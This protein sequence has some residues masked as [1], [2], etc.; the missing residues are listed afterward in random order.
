M[1]SN[2]LS[3]DWD[4][5]IKLSRHTDRFIQHLWHEYYARRQKSYLKLSTDQVWAALYEHYPE[6]HRVAFRNEEFQF[7]ISVLNSQSC[8]T[9]V[10]IAAEH[11]YMY[12]FVHRFNQP[13]IFNIDYHHDLYTHSLHSLNCGNWLWWLKFEE[14]VKEIWWINGGKPGKPKAGTKKL[15]RIGSIPNIQFNGIY[16]C[17]SKEYSLPMY[18]HYFI[19]LVSTLET[20]FNDVTIL[21]PDIRY[22]RWQEIA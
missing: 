20:R 17:K 6:L 1:S 15:P 3:I 14:K 12:S 9:P 19:Q 11:T 21:Q 7:L 2:I 18:D 4:Y 5:F 8:Q 10:V 22:D 13:N 16:L